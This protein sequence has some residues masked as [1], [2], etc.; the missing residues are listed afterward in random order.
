[1]ATTIRLVVLPA[2]AL[3]V[4]ACSWGVSSSVDRS[5][6]GEAWPLTVPSGLLTCDNTGA[7][8]LRTDNG[9]T[10]GV[11]ERALSYLDI[12]A[13]QAVD[14]AGVGGKKSLA[15]LVEAGQALCARHGE[16]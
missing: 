6:F 3:T 16:S 4:S 8:Y 15:P 2:F 7:I 1:M 10:F 12:A 11:N 9:Q 13:I 14:P 5:R